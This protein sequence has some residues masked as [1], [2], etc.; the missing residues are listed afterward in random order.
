MW[1]PGLEFVHDLYRREFLSSDWTLGSRHPTAP[2]RR[3]GGT[4]PVVSPTVDGLRTTHVRRR[5]CA[6][7]GD[8]VPQKSVVLVPTHPTVITF[9]L[10]SEQGRTVSVKSVDSV[11]QW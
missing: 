6:T 11:T 3:N 1:V 8:C 9:V 7:D 4:L 2:P 5:V 10:V